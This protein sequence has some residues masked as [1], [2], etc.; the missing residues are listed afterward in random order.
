MTLRKIVRRYQAEALVSR[1]PLKAQ[2][3][4]YQAMSRIICKM[5]LYASEF[6]ALSHP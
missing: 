1:T 6:Y 2:Q 3:I 4:G 5:K